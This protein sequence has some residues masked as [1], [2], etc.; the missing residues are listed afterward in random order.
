M[1][2]T[3]IIFLFS[4]FVSLV[5]CQRMQFAPVHRGQDSES[6]GDSEYNLPEH[7]KSDKLDM[8]I[9]ADTRDGMEQILQKNFNASFLHRFEPYDWKLAYTN[10]SVNKEFMEDA[11]KPEETTEED[12]TCGIGGWL[13]QFLK[14]AMGLYGVMPEIFAN[15]VYGVGSCTVSTLD[16]V[17]DTVGSAFQGYRKPEKSVNGRFLL[18]ERSGHE[19]ENYLAQEQEGYEEIISDTFKTGTGEYNQFDAPQ[20]QEGSSDP[21]AA[22]L[23]SILSEKDFFRKGSQ[24]FFIVVTPE[25]TKEVVSFSDIHKL[26]Q[27]VHGKEN[28]IQI[29]PVA[30]T[31]NSKGRCGKELESA[32]IDSPEEAVNLK[33]SISR[34]IQPVDI[35]DPDI[36]DQLVRQ[37]KRFVYP[38]G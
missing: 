25:D 36:A 33:K 29:I 18:F 3:K 21:L 5:Y 24:A 23:L 32:G 17:G 12:A 38:T 2:S 11:K 7:F 28:S 13:Y 16:A 30:L 9:V 10:T 20:I 35:C 22:A 14:V 15:G 31:K 34:E 6:R 37:M 8:I 26:F 1:N 4:V 27:Q 19:M